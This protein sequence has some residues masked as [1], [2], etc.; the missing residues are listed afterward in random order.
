MVFIFHRLSFPTLFEATLSHCTAFDIYTAF[1]NLFVILCSQ[2][3]HEGGPWVPITISHVREQSQ[4]V[5]DLFEIMGNLSSL[6]YDI[7]PPLSE[8]VCANRK[9]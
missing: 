8:S 9:T 6:I 7:L 4:E 2:A 1:Y 5:N 3:P